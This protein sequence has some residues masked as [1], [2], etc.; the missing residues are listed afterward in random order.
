MPQ[1]SGQRSTSSQS[2]TGMSGSQNGVR[3]NGTQV[4]L[5][6][7]WASVPVRGGK[8]TT[9]CLQMMAA[10][11]EAAPSTTQQQEHHEHNKPVTT[12]YQHS[13]LKSR[14]D[15]ERMYRHS[16][17]DPAKFWADIAS[18]YH[19]EQKVAQALH[20]CCLSLLAFQHIRKLSW[21]LESTI[22]L[23]CCCM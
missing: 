9:F 17:E 10:A 16:V 1:L 2:L 12:P 6:D 15:Y 20:V 23:T 18:T 4:L 11:T 13:L 8:V 7:T 5:G 14:E 3:P 21:Q 19:W 22:C